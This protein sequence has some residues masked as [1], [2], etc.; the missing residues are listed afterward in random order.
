MQGLT[1]KDEAEI[2]AKAMK[3]EWKQFIARID[4]KLFTSDTGRTVYTRQADL[5]RAIKR[6]FLWHIRDKICQNNPSLD[7]YQSTE[8]AEKELDSLIN[9]W[10][11]NG[12]I[13][14]EEIK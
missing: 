14:I 9:E 2:I 11:A 3:S 7:W 4:G 5:I 1:I 6:V 10:L 13:V 12:T 8:V